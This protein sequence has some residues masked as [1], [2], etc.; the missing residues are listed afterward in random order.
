ME[1][2]IIRVHVTERVLFAGLTWDQVAEDPALGAKRTQLVV[3][4]AT[5]LTE[6]RMIAFERETERFTITDLGRTA[7][8]G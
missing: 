1:S 7:S 6:A 2:N 8:A 3:E 4:A 5:R